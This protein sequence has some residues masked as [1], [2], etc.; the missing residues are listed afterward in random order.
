MGPHLKTRHLPRN[1]VAFFQQIPC[2]AILI[3]LNLT[4]PV[5]QR[6]LEEVVACLHPLDICQLVNSA[7][8]PDV[9]RKGVDLDLCSFL[10]NAFNCRVKIERL[11]RRM[12]NIFAI[13]RD[14]QG[15]VLVVVEK[16]HQFISS[17]LTAR[18]VQGYLIAELSLKDGGEE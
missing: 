14:L 2:P 3:Q 6:H 10:L 9:R 5:L 16:Q 11:I 12:S 15:P 4:F 7:T 1:T 17:A 13:G 8:K 18:L